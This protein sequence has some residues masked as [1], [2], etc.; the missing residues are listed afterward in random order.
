[1]A[2]R[3]ARVKV[4]VKPMTHE[5]TEQVKP[6]THETTEQLVARKR[7]ELDARLLLDRPNGKPDEPVMPLRATSTFEALGGAVGALV[8]RKQIQYGDSF[9]QSG[10]VMAILYPNGIKVHQMQDALLV[11]RI[12]DKLFRIAQR[13]LDGQDLGGEDPYSDIAGYG[14]LGASNKGES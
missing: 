1:M 13:G 12:M 7:S 5:T 11:V 2:F 10:K 8:T 3:W 9:G 4:K 14:L 6:M